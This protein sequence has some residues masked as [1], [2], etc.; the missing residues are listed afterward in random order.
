M[1][2]HH[3]QHRRPIR[4]NSLATYAPGQAFIGAKA[5]VHYH[6]PRKAWMRRHPVLSIAFLL[7]TVSMLAGGYVVNLA[8]ST[9]SALH[10]V[11]APPPSVIMPPQDSSAVG[12]WTG[13]AEPIAPVASP[14]ASPLA[15]PVAAQL[16]SVSPV[17]ATPATDETPEPATP[18]AELRVDTAPA[19]QAVADAGDDYGQDAG[20]VNSLLG[21]AGDVSGLAQ[22]AAAASGFND[23]DVPEMT[24]MLM[25]VDAR[26][27]QAID[28]GVNSD[29]LA[30]VHLN[31]ETG[32]C[33]LLNIPRDSRVN[34]PGYGLTKINHALA[35]GGIPYQQLVVEE[36]LGVSIDRFAL[37][38]FNG[39]I[40]LV[41]AMNGVTVEVTDSFF[42]LGTTFEPG[43]RTLTGL[44]A[45][46][47]SRYR[48]GPDGDF[49]RIR[50]Q[51]Q[52]LR[53]LIE[54]A[55]LQDPLA[56]VRDVLP[57]IESHVRTDL[58]PLEMVVLGTH[59][60]STCTDE[61]LNTAT[62]EGGIATFYDP[63]YSVNLSYVVIDEGEVRR[64]VAELLDD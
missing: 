33:R 49:G 35:V 47:Y 19:Q 62:L 48:G 31:P 6:G 52:V 56:L 23:S 55:S 17:A 51:Q 15:S 36:F 39:I 38:D 54:Q 26:D 28:I 25:G 57:K 40:S 37:I 16:A 42:L 5:P 58:T 46:R 24:I 34:L 50:R 60:R 8:I 44:E 1:S 61:T 11:S 2:L 21:G 12:G 20:L 32:S 30:V 22:G 10:S 59:F 53:S 63:L 14:M 13:G 7:F 18:A 27:N 4:R 29:V 43:V 3:P 45:L 41:D 64:K 9:V